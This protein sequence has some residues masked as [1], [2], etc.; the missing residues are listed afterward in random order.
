MGK[1]AGISLVMAMWIEETFPELVNTGYEVTSEIN[2]DYN[3]IAWA[4][5]DDK[6][7]WSH[8][9]G[10]RWPGPRYPEVENLVAVLV[11]MGFERCENKDLEAGY[12]KV[13]V[14]ETDGCWS[15]AARQLPDGRLD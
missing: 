7:W 9:P 14:F 4:V 6:N 11:G 2:D 13:A 15:H 1:A 12:E 3:C 8:L 5:R 10:Y